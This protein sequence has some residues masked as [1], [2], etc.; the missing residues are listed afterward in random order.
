MSAHPRQWT[1]AEDAELRARYNAGHSWDEIA[2]GLGVSRFSAIA[3][4]QRIGVVKHNPE[5]PRTNEVQSPLVARSLEGRRC[6][7]AGDPITWL[8][9]IAGTLLE[10]E[11]FE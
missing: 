7:E 2:A 9:I 1:Q 4:G 10:G 6:L 11:P 8:P 3:R 5:R